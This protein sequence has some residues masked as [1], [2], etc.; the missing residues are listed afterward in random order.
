MSPYDFTHLAL[1]AIDC[2][3]EGRTKLQKTIYFLGVLSDNVEELDYRR[4]F[5]GPHSDAV[6]EALGFLKS[7]EFLEETVG[8]YGAQKIDGFEYRRHDFHLT[9]AGRRIA[10]KKIRLNS[11]AWNRIKV[12]VDRVKHAHDVDYMVM[13]I[14]AK[15]LFTLREKGKPVTAE[16]IRKQSELLGWKATR[17]QVEQAICYLR[18]LGLEERAHLNRKRS[19]IRQAMAEDLEHQSSSPPKVMTQQKQS[20]RDMEITL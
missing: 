13:T 15:N 20:T 11:E 4:H 14:A 17:E 6:S 2:R 10:D 18:D 5:Y 12:A 16:E 7:R 8:S 19:S 9:E 3:V 1:R